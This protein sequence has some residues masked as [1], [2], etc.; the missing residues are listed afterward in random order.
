MYSSVW[1]DVMVSGVARSALCRKVQAV[2]RE[3]ERGILGRPFYPTCRM[4]YAVR[5]SWVIRIR[6]GFMG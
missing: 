5:S 1:N 2:T 6:R 3:E 4:R